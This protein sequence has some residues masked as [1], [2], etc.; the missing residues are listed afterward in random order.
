MSGRRAKF[1]AENRRY[2]PCMMPQ[3]NWAA[4]GAL[5]ILVVYQQFR[6]YLARRES[7]KR[8]E[9]FRIVTENAADMIALV[10]VKGHRLYNSPAYKRILGYSSAELGETSSFEQIHPDDRFKVLEA[11]REARSTG[12]GKKLDYR[13]RHKDGTWRVLESIASTIRDEKGEVA[14]MVIVNRDVTQRK[15]AEELLEHNSFHDALTGLPNRRLFLDRLQHLFAR[16]QRSPDRQYAVLFVDLDG[17]KVFNDTMG[18]AV[19][20]QVI[21]EIGH[22]LGACL[23]D[24]DTVS[25]AQDG[26]AMRSAVLSRMGGDEFTILLEGVTDPSDAMRAGQ[27]ILSSV[28][29][30]FVVEGRE[31]RTSASVGIAL[32][33][34]PHE[35]AED[36][37]QDADV[38]M[39]RAKAMGGSRCEMFDEAMHARAVNQ[40]KLEGELRQ[41]MEQRQF[42]VFY[43]PIVNLETKQI[44]GF[45]ALLR[46]QHPEQGLISPFRFIAAAADTGLLVSTGRWLILEACKQ[47]RAWKTEIPT[48]EAASISVNVSARQLDDARFVT[49]LEATLRETGIDPS[50][51]HLEMTESVAGADP[52]LTAT[53]LSHLKHLR[54]GVILDHFG[55]GNSS[56]SGLR[57]LP[58]EAL[59]IDRS[60][61]SGMLSDRGD[62]DT[63]ELIILLSH[64]LKLKVIA[65]GIE[66]AKQLDRLHEL[67]CELGQGHFFSQPM[68]AAA[69]E[70][71]LRQRGPVSHAKVAKA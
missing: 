6:M 67:G 23:R 8:E 27:R 20:D 57:Q 12:V 36:L 38:A 33:K 5:A 16:A 7:K 21:V 54:V 11:A 34:L 26:L 50:Q 52:K 40:L 15:R 71:L 58:I 32:N 43:Q 46:W 66:S 18:P 63:V 19:G 29:E 25:R 17:F 22:R 4:L 55:T 68:E 56:L 2:L 47:L 3:W 53:V 42:R 1:S 60:L 49:G 69:A 24:E 9:L 41:A 35:H 45:E 44:T 30:P 31:V 37:L 14:K 65:E 39:R 48:M 59:K 13:I 10:D 70:R 64:K 61:V 62:C 28:A 51:L